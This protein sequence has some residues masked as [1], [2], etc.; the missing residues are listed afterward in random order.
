MLLH[1]YRRQPSSYIQ[2]LQRRDRDY[3]GWSLQTDKR[4]GEQQHDYVNHREG[5]GHRRSRIQG[6]HRKLSRIRRENIYALCIR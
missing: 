5:Q 2:V 4:W 1:V 6:V 3:R